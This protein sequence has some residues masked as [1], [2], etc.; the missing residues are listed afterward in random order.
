MNV[1]LN[2]V[3]VNAMEENLDYRRNMITTDDVCALEYCGGGEYHRI[4]HRAFLDKIIEKLEAGKEFLQTSC[5]SNAL[6]TQY[7]R[8]ANYIFQ[9]AGYTVNYPVNTFQ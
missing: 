3:R 2:E 9:Y 4:T 1:L 5:G 6:C 7:G 8:M